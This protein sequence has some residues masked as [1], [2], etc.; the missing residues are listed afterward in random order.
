MFWAASE[1]NFSPVLSLLL[2]LAWIAMKCCP[3]TML[4]KTPKYHRLE[5]N[6]KALLKNIFFYFDLMKKAILRVY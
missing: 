6:S 2:L 4:V 1:I 3:A 5:K